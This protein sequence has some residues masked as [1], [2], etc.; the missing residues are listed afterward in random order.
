MTELVLNGTTYSDSV[1]Q[2]TLYMAEGGHR[3]N[4]F[5]MFVDLFIEMDNRLQLTGLSLVGSSSSSIAVASSGTITPTLST[6]KGWAAGARVRL[7]KTSSPANYVEG[8]LLA[9]D[10]STGVSSVLLTN[11]GGTGTHTD[12]T[13]TLSGDKGNTGATGATGVLGVTVEGRTTNTQLVA[14]DSGKSITITGAGGFTQT[15]VAA[16]TLGASWGIFYQNDSTG[17]V[18]LDPNSTEQIDGATTKKLYPGQGVWIECNATLL[19]TKGLHDRDK[20]L[21]QVLLM[22]YVL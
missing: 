13:V 9:Y 5:P 18:T 19:R 17:I 3:D 14:A 11:S 6:N 8:I 10:I 1:V 12:W 4:L 7:A 20:L 16:A 21:G 15:F 2:G 22:R